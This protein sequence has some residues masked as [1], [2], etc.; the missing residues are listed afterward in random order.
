MENQLSTNQERV[1]L[2]WLGQSETITE[3]ARTL[4]ES[5][6]ANLENSREKVQRDANGK[7]LPG[8]TPLPGAGRPKGSGL[9][10][11]AIKQALR[12][13]KADEVKETLFGLMSE[14][15]KDSVRLAAISEIIDRSEGKA[16]QNVRMAGV[17]MVAAPSA[18]AIAALDGWAQDD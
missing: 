7:L 15:D 12:E 18:E 10:S 14:A 4:T 9:V 1:P 11:D 16:M 3:S 2:H 8:C 17:F 5:V 13:G 6:E